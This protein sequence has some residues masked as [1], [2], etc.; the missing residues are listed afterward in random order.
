MLDKVET[1]LVAASTLAHTHT[2]VS[3]CRTSPLV[4]LLRGSLCRRFQHVGEKASVRVCVSYCDP[5]IVIDGEL[6]LVSPPCGGLTRN[7][8]KGAIVRV[9][10]TLCSHSEPPG[11]VFLCL[12]AAQYR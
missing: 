10:C 9:F 4:F 6:T 11:I 1:T 12:H 2:L 5:M 8:V 3:N 7:G